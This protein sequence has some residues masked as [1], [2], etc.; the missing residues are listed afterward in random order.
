MRPPEHG[1]AGTVHA[2]HQQVQQS[3]QLFLSAVWLARVST[4]SNV[5]PFILL[6]VG[7]PKDFRVSFLPREVIFCLPPEAG[8]HPPPS[9]GNVWR[10]R[11]CWESQEHVIQQDRETARVVAW[12][13][14]IRLT[15]KNNIHPRFVVQTGDFVKHGEAAV[16]SLSE[17]T[18]LENYG[19]RVTD[20]GPQ[21]SYKL[22]LQEPWGPQ[23]DSQ[24]FNSK[25][26]TI[27]L[28]D[29]S[30]VCPG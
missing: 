23:W 10:W 17:S 1:N 8:E 25:L 9:W 20:D 30:W 21:E 18:S 3:Q 29:S 16:E 5:H 15:S 2:V 24:S 13:T 6:W 27:L 11:E 22:A 4:P 19:A 14:K 28:I 26:I 12:K 7:G